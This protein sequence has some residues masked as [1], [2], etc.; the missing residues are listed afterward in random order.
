MR[1]SLRRLLLS[2]GVGCPPSLQRESA[3][4]WGFLGSETRG[5]CQ[6]DSKSRNVR[7]QA[8]QMKLRMSHTMDTETEPQLGPPLG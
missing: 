3:P 4:I 7:D 8:T 5:R 1:T 6:G 2:G